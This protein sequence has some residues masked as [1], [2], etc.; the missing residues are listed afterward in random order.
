MLAQTSTHTW[1]PSLT[2]YGVESKSTL[3]FVMLADSWLG[4]GWPQNKVCRLAQD[5]EKLQ[6]RFFSCTNRRTSSAS[7]RWLVSAISTNR[8][9]DRVVQCQCCACQGCQKSA[10]NKN[11]HQQCIWGQ[12]PVNQSNKLNH[13][14]FWRKKGQNDT[15]NPAYIKEAPAKSLV[16]FKTNCHSGMSFCLGSTQQVHI[17]TSV[18]E[19]LVT[20]GVKMIPHPP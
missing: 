14:I 18:R 10:G 5:E 15:V 20:K 1:L 4:E 3:N 13:Q 12:V 19:S 9:Y 11:V 16:I 2:M 6:N 7:G 8:H 17:A